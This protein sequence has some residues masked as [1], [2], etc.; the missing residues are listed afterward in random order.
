VK[1]YASRAR[2]QSARRPKA[3]P[4]RYANRANDDEQP[5]PHEWHTFDASIQVLAE[6]TESLSALVREWLV[7]G[8]EAVVQAVKQQLAGN[9]VP[10]ERQLPPPKGVDDDGPSRSQAL[11]R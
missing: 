2:Q 9:A 6:E 1:R 4:R 7:R 5:T 11:H 10:S 8:I 3:Q